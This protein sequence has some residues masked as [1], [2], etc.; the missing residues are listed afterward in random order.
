MAAERP[1][2][3]VVVDIVGNVQ[4]I[5]RS[6]L[7]LATVELKTQ[8][9]EIAR[10]SSLIGAALVAAFYAV[11]LLLALVVL[12]LA[13]VMDAWLATLVTLAG[14]GCVAAVL[15]FL[16]MRR[17]NRVH[18]KPEKTVRTVEE[19]VSWMKAQVK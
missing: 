7:R 8:A 5:V 12:L 11:G 19:N 1:I 14:L 3:A 18:L 4:E 15:L 9:R 2:S 13:R 16:G 10:S 6:E 17:W